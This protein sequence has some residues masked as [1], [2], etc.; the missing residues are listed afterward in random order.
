MWCVGSSRQNCCT[1][2]ELRSGNFREVTGDYQSIIQLVTV[3]VAQAK[4]IAGLTMGGVRMSAYVYT[5]APKAR[6]Q[7]DRGAARAGGHA[8]R[9]PYRQY[10]LL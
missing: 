3:G 7:L 10:G 1:G 6:R 4:Q 5:L 9:R 2:P 8:V